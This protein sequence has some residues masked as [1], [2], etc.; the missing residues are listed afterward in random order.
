MLAGGADD[1]NGGVVDRE[2]FVLL[3]GFSEG[4]QA[5]SDEV[6]E[7]GFGRA[8]WLRG[9]WIRSVGTYNTYNND[10]SQSMKLS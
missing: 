2:L 1:A 6:F 4:V 10:D 7:V 3:Q 9:G 8:S 5:V